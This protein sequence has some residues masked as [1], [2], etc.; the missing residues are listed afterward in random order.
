MISEKIKAQK[1]GAKVI[2]QISADLQK[3][4]PSLKGFSAGNLKKI[5]LFA[6]AYEHYLELVLCR[7]TNKSILDP[8]SYF[9]FVR[10]QRTK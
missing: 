2:D 5:R 4:L 7:R 10:Q 3:E 6:E 1:W 9:Q 8:K